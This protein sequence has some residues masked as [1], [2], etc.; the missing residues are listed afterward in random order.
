M[1]FPIASFLSLRFFLIIFM[2]DFRIFS[3]FLKTQ[4][5]VYW[6]V[7]KD[8][9][10]IRVEKGVESLCAGIKITE[11]FAIFHHHTRPFPAANG[12]FNFFATVFV[13]RR[14]FPNFTKSSTCNRVGISITFV[15]SEPFSYITKYP[16]SQK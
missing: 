3:S 8:F 1:I 16:F 9:V 2:T 13:L 14:S 10:G 11:N 15:D 7:I 4:Q 6:K 5:I 12:S